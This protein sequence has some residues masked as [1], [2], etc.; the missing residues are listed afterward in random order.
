M[1]AYTMVLPTNLKPR[2]DSSFDIRSE[3]FDVAGGQLPGVDDFP[4]LVITGSSAGV[5]D[6]LPW[7]A[8]LKSFLVEARGRTA[9]VGVCFGHQV[10]AE[11]FGGQVI[12]SP[13]GWGVGLHSYDVRTARPWMDGVGT[14]K[15]PASHQDQVVA[16][17]PG[18]EVVAGSE[19]TPFGMLDYGSDR[20]ISLQLH[21]E[22]EP[23]YARALIDLGYADTLGRRDEV[24]RQ[25]P[26]RC[27]DRR[28]PR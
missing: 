25:G 28:S 16:A 5:Y 9:L 22:F 23:A 4:A 27:G 21:P 12:K 10:M 8:P 3:T 1:Y 15:A 13:K 18:A 19:F 2:F 20:A 26:T 11:A 14:F 6:P 17:P 24:R 7:I